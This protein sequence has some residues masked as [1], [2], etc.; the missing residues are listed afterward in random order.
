ML[1]FL[2]AGAKRPMFAAGAAVCA[3]AML[4]VACDTPESPVWDVDLAAPLPTNR[5]TIVDF[6]PPEIRTDTVDGRPAFVVTTQQDSVTR[7]LGRLCQACQALAGQTVQVPGFVYV[8]SLDVLLP[9]T[10]FGLEIVRAALTMQFRNELNFDPLRPD[11]NPANA[12]SVEFAVRDLG[13]GAEIERTVLRG[14]TAS[15]PPGT[16]RDV[17][18]DLADED[19]T[20]GIRIVYS[21]DSPNDGQTVQVDTSMNARIKG[22]LAEI[23]VAAA[24]IQ[25]QTDTLN[26]SFSLELDAD[27]RDEIQDRAQGG[28]FELR[29]SH[30]TDVTGVLDV[31]LAGSQADL[32]SDDPFREV[33]LGMLTL[34]PDVPQTGQLTAAEVELIASF[35]EVFAGYR[36]TATGTLSGA[37]AN[38]LARFTPDQFLEVQIKLFSR[39]RLGE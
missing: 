2:G 23:V 4:T 24:T 10:V 20:R 22:V 36:A 34:T 7:S 11:P 18:V 12:G 35:D 38:N 21:I 29:L 26:E 37:F 14:D 39:V 9:N 32:F 16:T 15:I 5:I 31:S 17:D 28:R 8:D 30:N 13:T 1:P 27:L 33:R 19:I 3:A 6:L 25:V